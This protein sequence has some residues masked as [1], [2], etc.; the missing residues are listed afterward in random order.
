M[1]NFPVYQT[2]LFLHI[3]GALGFFIAVGVFYA[4]VLG[5]R[6]AQ[7]VGSI[8]LWTGAAAGVSRS[9]FP[10]SFL[11]IVI[12]GIYMV[13][14]V[15]GEKAPWAGVALIAFIILGVAATFIQGRRMGALGQSAAQESESAAVTGALWTQ[16]HDP[17]TWVAVNASAAFA[18]GIVYLMTL[19][20]DALGS[21]IALLIALVVGLAFGFLTQGRPAPAP[22]LARE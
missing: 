13:V 15:W 12:A 14:T 5:V 9:L 3:L 10:L 8:K 21:V 7:T 20:P 16:A 17:L 11:V 18:I 22:A 2:A 6:R 1:D 4:A 19:K